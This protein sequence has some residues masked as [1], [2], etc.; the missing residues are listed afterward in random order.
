M[1]PSPSLE[2]TAPAERPAPGRGWIGFALFTVPAIVALGFLSGQASNSGYANGWFA[3]LAK[4]AL[5]PPGWAFGAAW[6]LLYVLLGLAVARILATPGSPPRRY[7]LGVFFLQLVLNLTWSPLFF[8]AHLVLPAFFL[9]LA[10][11]ALA[12]VTA[13]LFTRLDR[14]A[15]LMFVPYIAWLVF[16]SYLNWEIHLLN[17]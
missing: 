15:G 16:A 2:P 9:I 4:P 3:A 17:P 5:M 11:L 1:D 6:T 7:A 12:I 8:G 14:P 10:I 13:V